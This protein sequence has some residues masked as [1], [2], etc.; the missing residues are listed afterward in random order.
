MRG[1]DVTKWPGGHPGGSGKHRV[2]ATMESF[3]SEISP[4]AGISLPKW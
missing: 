2:A 4:K 3:F 1:I